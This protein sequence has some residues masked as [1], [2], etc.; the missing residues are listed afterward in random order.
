MEVQRV[1]SIGHS[2]HT[3][4]NFVSL[5]AEFPIS[6]V[7]DIRTQPYS[8]RLPHFNSPSLDA[9]LRRLA[10]EYL[11]LGSHLGARWTDPDVLSDDGQVS[12]QKVFR[13]AKYERGMSELEGLIKKSR[14]LAIMC[15]E[16]DPLDCHRFPMVAR[17]LAMKGYV[18]KH[19]MPNGKLLSH[20][21]VEHQLLQRFR[22]A[23]PENDF[24][25]GPQD[26]AAR[27]DSA[28]EALNRKIG[29]RPSQPRDN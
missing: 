28:Y 2:N 12:Y 8:R 17:P 1:F 11:Y 20:Q 14:G 4:G 23:V 21:V 5:I 10:I 3:L 13:T 16:G 25:T 7:V 15:A 18:V 6:Q 27:L 29:W 26:Q 24:F 19:V 22:L 9:A